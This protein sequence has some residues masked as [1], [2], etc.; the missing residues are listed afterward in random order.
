[1]SVHQQN[2]AGQQQVNNGGDITTSTRAGAPPH[3]KSLINR[4]K[5]LEA[6]HRERMD[7]GAT[8]KAGGANPYLE[9]MGAV[10]GR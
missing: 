6:Q 3:G 2:I 9:A 8:G 4:N 7:T 5:L 1:M 10:H